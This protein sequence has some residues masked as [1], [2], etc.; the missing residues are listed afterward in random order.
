MCED[1]GETVIISSLLVT[2]DWLNS[3]HMHSLWPTPLHSLYLCIVAQSR[4]AYIQDAFGFWL[5]YSYVIIS[6]ST[7]EPFL[8]SLQYH[9][10]ISNNYWS[11][12]DYLHLVFLTNFGK[13][14]YKITQFV[15]ILWTVSLH[16]HL[17]LC[18]FRECHISPHFCFPRL[19]S[20]EDKYIFF[21][22]IQ[23]LAAYL[24]VFLP[25]HLCL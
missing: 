9:Y 23:F 24:P 8:V 22:K 12:L 7:L 21:T 19:F 10:S 11:I 18:Y 17:C 15:D 2:W 3:F 25:R 5:L 13:V 14:K 4:V 20:P 1:T 6:L 16:V